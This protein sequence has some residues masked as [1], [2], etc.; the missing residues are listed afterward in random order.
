MPSAYAGYSWIFSGQKMSFLKWRPHV[1][2]DNRSVI[3]LCSQISLVLYF[4]NWC[5]IIGYREQGIVFR[6]LYMC[7]IIGI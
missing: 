5:C 1:L 7:S 2:I 3:S 4:Y 6:V